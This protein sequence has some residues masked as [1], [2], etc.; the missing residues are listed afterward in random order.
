MAARPARAVAAAHVEQLLHRPGTWSGSNAVGLPGVA[1]QLASCRSGTTPQVRAR[2]WWRGGAAVEL[3]L[4]GCRWCG[5]RCA[6]GGCSSCRGS[7]L[8]AAARPLRMAA[9]GGGGAPAAAQ[10]GLPFI[11]PSSNGNILV[12]WNPVTQKEAWRGPANSAAGYNQGGTLT[13]AREPR[14]RE[15]HGL[16]AGV[17]SRYRR[18]GFGSGNGITR[19]PRSA[20]DL[21][22]GWQA[23]H[24][25]CRCDRCAAVERR[26]GGAVRAAA[27]ALLVRAPPLPAG[28][29]AAAGGDAALPLQ[30][31][32]SRLRLAC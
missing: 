22:A 5:G 2:R 32:R 3:A 6:P 9:D 12:A 23:V 7:E 10:P 26:G 11:G 31:V 16:S 19:Q 15:R 18:T 30:P 28:A 17:Q 29:P 21:H 20:D 27:A 1:Q 8:H 25:R 13:T 24:R 14:V 4:A